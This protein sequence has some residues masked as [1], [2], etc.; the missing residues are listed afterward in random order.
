MSTTLNLENSVQVPTQILLRFGNF[1]LACTLYA[2][3]LGHSLPQ[4][5]TN[6][7]QM[8][9]LCGFAIYFA[10]ELVADQRAREQRKSLHDVSNRVNFA[11]R[12]LSNRLLA[13]QKISRILEQERRR[14]C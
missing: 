3:H 9:G 6:L 10:L 4:E 12:Q 1:L 8:A 13:E 11:D 5:I 7:C 2:V 14:T